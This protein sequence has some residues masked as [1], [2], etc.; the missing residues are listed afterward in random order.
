LEA[1]PEIASNE[2]RS[3]FS[4]ALNSHGH[5]FQYAVLKKC[6]NVAQAL[7]RNA[8]LSTWYPLASE[9]PVVVQGV[10]TRIDFVLRRVAR[11][12][13]Q[14]VPVYLLAEC[15]RAN[16]ALSNWCFAKAPYVHHAWPEQFE[17]FIAER[18]QSSHEAIGVEAY[19]SVPDAYHIG[20]E[21]KTKSKGDNKGESGQAIENA[22]SQILRGLNGFIETLNQNIQLLHEQSHA[23]ILPVIFTTAELYGS[24][25][26]L[27]DADLKSGLTNIADSELKLLSWICYQYH[28]SP[29]IKHTRSPIIKPQDLG[30]ILQREYI[31]T[32]PIVNSAGIEPFFAWLSGLPFE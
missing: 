3:A 24:D 21:I 7:E 1:S 9:F 2:I 30:P 25:A 29:G 20:I 12:P 5:A 26:K 27:S 6:R 22:A 4:K 31:R 11:R 16:P 23:Y 28:T 19:Y 14:D 10:G 8:A 18:F 17:P 15:K 13:S 32:I